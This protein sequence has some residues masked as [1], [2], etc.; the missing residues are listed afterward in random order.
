MDKQTWI[1]IAIILLIGGGLYFSPQEEAESLPLVEEG[2]SVVEEANEVVE[3]E[4]APAPQSTATFVINTK[5]TITSW[6]FAGRYTGN[7]TLT[8][9]A[10]TELARLQ[11]LL[12]TGKYSDYDLYNGIGNNYTYL[13]D[14][15]KALAAYKKAISLD[16]KR[17]L[18]YMNIGNLM[19]QLGAYNTAKDAYAKAV[20]LEP[21]M[22]Q[23]KSAQTEFLE[24]RFPS[25]Q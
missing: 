21:D 15:E 25:V 2:A 22:T 23:Y 5:D 4:K 16:S 6:Q 20:A 3:E 1:G 18:V 19:E 9:N 14:G 10:Q 7:E 8:M 12:G 17:A 13:G 24:R 11:G